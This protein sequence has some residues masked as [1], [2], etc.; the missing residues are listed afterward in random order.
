M[1]LTPVKKAPNHYIYTNKYNKSM[2]HS[3]PVIGTYNDASKKLA[4]GGC[5]LKIP[6][7]NSI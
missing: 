5:V 4:V 7:T 1:T 2:E 6:F 3:Q